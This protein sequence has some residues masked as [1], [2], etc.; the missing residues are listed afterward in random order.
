MFNSWKLRFQ[1]FIDDGKRQDEAAEQES[2]AAESDI[3]LLRSTLDYLHQRAISGSA[4][5]AEQSD[6]SPSTN[7]EPSS[8]NETSNGPAQPDA[9]AAEPVAN[10][11]ITEA[12]V[13]S[14]ETP[15]TAEPNDT[16]ETGEDA[17]EA[18]KTLETAQRFIAEQRKIAEALLREVC[19]FE[20]RFKNQAKAAQAARAYATAKEK[21]DSAAILAQQAKELVQSASVHRSAVAA[22]LREA[23]ANVAASHAEAQ[24][25]NAAVA[26]LEQRLRHAQQVAAEIAVTLHQREARVKE[27]AA[28]ESAAAASE[29]QAAARVASCQTTLLEA[30]KEAQTAK[31]HADE[32]ISESLAGSPSFAGIREVQSLAARL[33]DAA[34]A[35]TPETDPAQTY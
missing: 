29:A 5:N 24:T 34:S 12:I 3:T 21:T 7:T 35:L 22:E 23:E 25:A 32:L 13:V 18:D 31:E 20:E 17:A 14:Y 28:T 11:E 4:G 33:A 9:L 30:E 15:A 16:A 26:D 2:I 6:V 27:C 8:V 19:A 10:V 1:S